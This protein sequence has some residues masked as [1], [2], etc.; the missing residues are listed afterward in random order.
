MK[1]TNS[2][3]MGHGSFVTCGEHE[4]GPESPIYIC[5][6]CLRAKA[7]A[8]KAALLGTIRAE[9]ETV[10]KWLAANLGGEPFGEIEDDWFAEIIAD[11]KLKETQLPRPPR[12]LN[13]R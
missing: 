11:L 5:E 10:D 3:T 6:S 2:K 7:D 1:C 4:Y 9:W 12:N 13:R 8:F